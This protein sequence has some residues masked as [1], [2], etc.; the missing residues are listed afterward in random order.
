MS[1]EDNRRNLLQQSTVFVLKVG[2][3]RIRGRVLASS[4]GAS[5][6][7]APPRGMIGDLIEDW[8]QGGV[9]KDSG[10]IEKD[11]FGLGNI[12][13]VLRDGS[14]LTFTHLLLSSSRRRRHFH[15]CP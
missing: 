9:G 5:S 14:A 12:R 11:G 2:D 8:V 13:Q 6:M 15:S 3:G 10:E 1:H 7:G 4:M